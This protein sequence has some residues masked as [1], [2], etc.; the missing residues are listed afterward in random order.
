MCVSCD[1]DW[2]DIWL[3]VKTFSLSEGT[4]LLLSYKVIFVKNYKYKQIEISGAYS[5]SMTVDIDNY[6]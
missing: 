2:N 5:K 4:R 6:R 3:I 1:R